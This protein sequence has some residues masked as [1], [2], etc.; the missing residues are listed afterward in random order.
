MQPGER[1]NKSRGKIHY[2]HTHTLAYIFRMERQPAQDVIVCADCSARETSE[3]EKRNHALRDYT[4]AQVCQGGV[5]SSGAYRADA[6]RGQ[7]LT[8]S[9]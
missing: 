5:T 7:V 6:A 1:R 2:L 8:P 3:R 9:L 4:Y